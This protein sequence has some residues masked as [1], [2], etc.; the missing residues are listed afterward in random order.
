MASKTQYLEKHG[1]QYR[2]QVK[3]PH[4]LRH[5]IGKARITHPLHTENLEEANLR[6][7]EHVARIKKTI[8]NARK[9]L[10]SDHPLIA[11][12][13]LFRERRRAHDPR[14]ESEYR[15]RVDELLAASEGEDEVGEFMATVLE[16]NLPVDDHL[17]AFVAH[18]D[19]RQKSQGD[20][21]RVVEW[22][23]DWLRKRYGDTDLENVT[24][25]SAGDF[26]TDRLMPGRSRSKASAYLGFLREYWRWMKQRGHVE[27]NPW[28]DQDLPSEPRRKLSMEADG[29]KRPFTNKEI[30]QLIYGP[31]DG[32]LADLMRVAAL[33][34][35]RIE[36]ICQLRIVDC[37]GG[38]FAIH[39]GKT[40]NARRT[41]PI[42]SD[43]A[44]IVERRTKGHQPSDFL[45]GE[46]PAPPPSRETRS[47]PASKKFTRYRRKQGVDER[48]NG[49]AKSNV[50]FHSFRRWFI[51]QAREGL[52]SANGAY[53]PWTIADVVGHDD[54][55][56]KE[57]LKL[58]MSVY[59]GSASDEAKRACV[60]AVR[61]PERLP[62]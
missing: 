56:V 32:Y 5:I 33:S 53:S 12:A 58:T 20:L 7:W 6:K 49:K 27:E 34:G 13:E 51:R 2:V 38:S 54:E 31:E 30:G 61:L 4:R 11:E 23:S 16:F 37:V 45:F 44:S 22:L 18:K 39:E 35:L 26:I 8:E 21:R 28:L 15:A 60:E 43:L 19:Y 52:A 57:L 46:L 14:A 3:V 24:R 59:A 41:V 17:D 40:V 42:H 1:R 9:A 47:D 62:K 29:G 10:E 48:P 36:E 25:K 50:D 55:G